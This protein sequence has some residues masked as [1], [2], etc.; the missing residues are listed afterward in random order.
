VT[1]HGKI[2]GSCDG[3]NEWDNAMRDLAPHILNMAIVKVGE[4]NLVDM[5]ELDN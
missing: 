3:K 1:K 4:Q 2:D 5:A